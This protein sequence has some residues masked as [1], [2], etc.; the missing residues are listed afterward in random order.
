MKKIIL[1]H[2]KLSKL[3]KRLNSF[4]PHRNGRKAY[5]YVIDMMWGISGAKRGNVCK[6]L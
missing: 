3:L 4:L 5:Y 6:V 1:S 2:P